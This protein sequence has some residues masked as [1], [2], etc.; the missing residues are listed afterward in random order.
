MTKKLLQYRHVLFVTIFLCI[1]TIARTQTVSITGPQPVNIGCENYYTATVSDVPSD[2]TIVDYKWQATYVGT[3]GGYIKYASAINNGVPVYT[4]VTAGNGLEFTAKTKEFWVNWDNTFAPSCAVQVMFKIR[5]TTPTTQPAINETN[6]FYLSGG[7]SSP[8]F[9]CLKGISS[10]LAFTGPTSV[11]KCCT[12]NVTY[13]VTNYGDATSFDNWTYPTGWTLISQSGNSITL[14]PDASTGG[15]VTCRVGINTSCPPI[16]KVATITVTRN[17]AIVTT[18]AAQF[19]LNRICPNSNYSFSI[20]PVCGATDYTWQFPAGFSITGYTN[21]KTTAN[22]TTGPTISSGNINIAAVFNGC[23][24]ATL[25]VPIVAITGSPAQVPTFNT[26][27]PNYHCGAWYV[28]RNGTNVPFVG[29]SIAI[30]VQTLTYTISSGWYFKNA[31]NQKVNMLTLNYNQLPPN[32]YSDECKTTGNYSVKANNCLGSSAATVVWFSRESDCWCYGWQ[33]Y[34]YTWGSNK[35]CRTPATGCST[36]C[37]TPPPVYRP[38]AIENINT[39]ENKIFPNPVSSVINIETKEQGIKTIR[40]VA[41]NG[42]VLYTSSTKQ[43]RIKIATAKWQNGIYFVEVFSNKKSII[44]EK[45]VL[46]K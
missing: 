34:P 38:I 28:C 22:V 20:N 8:I 45:I 32:I 44:K 14:R 23:S 26:D 15:N 33:N 29:S 4:T 36:L 18:V 16:Y 12:S 42:K 43:Q 27:A 37:S 46:K 35:P 30:D 10:N 9:I 39:L 31:N 11:Q 1:T 19:P 17:D 7:P 21:N 2:W 5:Y 24:N 6:P 3:N 13:S 25:S 41:L 40:V